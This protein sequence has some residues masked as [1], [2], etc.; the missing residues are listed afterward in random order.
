[1]TG[2][3]ESGA[4]ARMTEEEKEFSEL[5]AAVVAR[6]HAQ[7]GSTPPGPD[8]LAA[9]AARLHGMLIE[10][11]LPRPAAEGTAHARGGLTGEEI[12][13][14]AERVAG[15]GADPLLTEAV[16]QLVK[17]CFYPEIQVCCDSFREVA[18]DGVCHRQ[19]LA[20]A[21]GRISGS[22][23]V[24]CPHWTELPPARHA[25]FFAG[26][27]RGVPAVLAAHREVFRP[28]DFGALRRW[29][30]AKARRTVPPL[31]RA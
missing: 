9:V 28:P 12:A 4:L 30:H 24:D 29:L 5:V 7:N 31:R 26:E 8:V 16:R 1:M 20:R 11:G 19:E 15:R 18:S 27:W 23:C 2:R 13:I 3:R 6:F 17:A 25:E 21:R 14:L 22:H 10:R